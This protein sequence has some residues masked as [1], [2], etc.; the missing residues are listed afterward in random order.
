V[1]SRAGSLVYS[2]AAGSGAIE[3]QQMSTFFQERPSDSPLVESISR[4]GH[5]ES[6]SHMATADGCW[7]MIFSR[8]GKGGAVLF[9]GP[10]SYASPVSYNDGAE[11]I[12]I[13]FKLGVFMTRIESRRMVNATLK[14]PTSD[15]LTFRLAE[16]SWEWPTY[17]NAE[18]FVDK[19]AR[20]GL[21]AIDHLVAGTLFGEPAK[22]T[23]RSLQRRFLRVTGMSQSTLRQILKAEFATQLLQTGL[24]AAEAASVAGYFDQSHMTRWVRRLT[25]RTP[26]RIVRDGRG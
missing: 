22:L 23:A 14:Q 16:A 3:G 11:S 13:R 17:D 15:H 2:R 21:V 20:R 8:Q 18:A 10:K 9:C 7:D 5:T 24:P 6:G 4:S 26:G 1:F 25:G 19:L 12:G